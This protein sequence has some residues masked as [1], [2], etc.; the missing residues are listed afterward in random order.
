MKAI[1]TGN[2]YRIYDDTLKTYDQLPPEPFIVRFSNIGGFF[3]ERYSDIEINENKIYGVHP[4]KVKKVMDSFEQYNRSLGV[5]L[6]GD[7]GIGKSLFAKLL[8]SK[9]MERGLPLIIVDR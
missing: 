1:S 6:S 5:I 9:A 2:V 3:L 4:E 8:A 7:K